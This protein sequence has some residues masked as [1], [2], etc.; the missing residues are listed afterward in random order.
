V[1][2]GKL[3]RDSWLHEELDEGIDLGAVRG[4]AVSW[5]G[6]LFAVTYRSE[7]SA[8]VRGVRCRADGLR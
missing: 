6:E 8:W 2:D 5:S 3:H 1:V 7:G 4:A